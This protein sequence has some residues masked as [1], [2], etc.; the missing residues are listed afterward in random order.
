MSDEE[1][2][3]NDN[4]SKKKWLLL[5]LLLLL[6]I[7][8]IFAVVIFLKDDGT[9]QAL[10]ETVSNEIAEPQDSKNTLEDKPKNEDSKNDKGTTTNTVATVKTASKQVVIA[11]PG[12]GSSNAAANSSVQKE[13]V[14]VNIEDDSYFNEPVVLE[15]AGNQ[16]T[17][18]I[19]DSEGNTVT[20]NGKTTISEDGTYTLTI[21][22]T[23]G[24]E[25][26]VVFIVD[27]TAPVIEGVEEKLYNT[28]VT[29]SVK[30]TNL[31][32]VTLTKNGTN[33]EYS[34]GDSIEEDG[35]YTL[36]VIDK[37][38]NKASVS[39]EIDRTAPVCN[40]EY[41]ITTPTN[42]DV[43]VT[44][45]ASEPIF[46]YT[47]WD[48]AG[49][50]NTITK[51][52]T[53]NAEE[54]LLLKDEAGNETPVTVK[55]TN[56]D[57]DAPVLEVKANITSMTKKSVTIRIHANEQI[58]LPDN[59]WQYDDDTK[60]VIKKVY[61][62]NIETDV[63][64]KDLVGNEAT[65][66]IKITNIDKVAPTGSVTSSN[67]NG[68]WSTNK[69]VTA[70]LVVS[71]PVKPI[72][73]W[74][75]VDEYTYTK[76]YSSNQKVTVEFEDLVGN[77]G[78][79]S[80]EIKRIDKVPPVVTI[81]D[82]NK[83]QLEVH[84]PYVEKG[85]HAEDA[86][87][88]NVTDRVTKKY[89]FQAKGSS[90]WE[91]VNDIDTSKLG[92]YKITYTFTDKAGNEA[93][94]SRVV[95]IVDTT[96]PLL[97]LNGE[98]KMT[99][100]AGIDTYIELG[101]TAKDNYDETITN[102]QPKYIN[103]SVNNV[104]QGKVDA[105]D[106]T[107][108]GTYK[109]VYEYSDTSNN[110]GVDANRSDHAYVMRIVEVVDTTAP[111]LTLNGDAKIILEAGIDTY[112]ELGATV[113][114]NHDATI[115]NLQPKYINYSV[116]NVYQGKVNSVDNTK[117]GTYKIVYEHSDTSNNVGVDAN[118]SDH[119][120]VMRIV[121][122]VDTIAPTGKVT[123]SNNNGHWS[124][125]KDVTATLVVSE[126]IKPIDGWTKVDEYTY[127]K[128]Y[129][130]NQK[131]TV[132]FED[133]V[134][135]KGKV[136]FE[137]KRID[138][139]PPVVTI[140]D[141]NKYQLEVHSPYVEKGYHAEDAVDKNVT[142]RV[143]KKYQFQAKGSSNWEVV[144]DIDTSKLG[145]YKITY[146]FTD[147][148]G[149]EA[150]GSRV[151]EI[152]DTTAPLLTLNGDAKITLEYG[153]D[154]YV[155]LGATVTDNYDATITNLQPKYINYSVNNVF[156][157]TRYTM[158]NL[159]VGTYKVMY[160]YEDSSKN[161]GVD[162]NRSDHAYVMRTVTVV[163]TTAPTATVKYSTK[164]L[165]N[166]DVVVTLELSEE[167]MVS[168]AGTWNPASGY[169][170]SF[171][172]SYNRNTTQVVT[173]TDKYGNVGTVEV[174]IE[175][176]DKEAATVEFNVEGNSIEELEAVQRIIASEPIEVIGLDELV[177]VPGSNNTIY[178]YRYNLRNGNINGFTTKTVSVKDKAG[179]VTNTDIV[180]NIPNYV[181][182]TA[183]GT[184]ST[185]SSTSMRM[186]KSA[187]P[188]T[189]VASTSQ[190]TNDLNNVPTTP[191]IEEPKVEETPVVTDTP[192]VEE[193]KVEETPVVTETPVVEEPKVE[194]TPIVTETPVVEEPKVEETPVVTETPV[195]EEP[196]VE[197]TPVVTEVPVIEETPEVA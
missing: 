64:V 34:L 104:Y 63:V 83:Y 44:I 67:N 187:R 90:N 116:N 1:V 24:K 40:V 99:I 156:K 165:T 6:I 73:G 152:V 143:T 169:Q 60:M 18:T 35:E 128:V 161:I 9:A 155:E 189:S 108:L 150:S 123:S 163:D 74:T 27:T 98:A 68:H 89:Q 51:V 11:A 194:E 28:P 76:V 145:I 125:N 57:K 162:A 110:V 183:S 86:V 186:V 191:A 129:S 120:Y 168:N 182:T 38:G 134:G 180:I 3:N 93:S 77:K 36:E 41:S 81:T 179:N 69:D 15:I 23:D 42:Q 85:Y 111:L 56:I 112:T 141:S 130:S 132:E 117:L 61:R 95:E 66:H 78:K 62:Q 53:E 70:T 131:V 20:Y 192:V 144:N 46:G 171:K 65:A 107:K 137:I 158:D 7:F 33:V 133:L 43:T 178:E 47:G 82:S 148:A 80:F 157:E 138:K 167:A 17:A 114:D 100:E 102:L 195:V 149:N 92:I 146:I 16:F 124:T 122:V 14:K 31:D 109:I 153:R 96:A 177:V 32:K 190:S 2:R 196:K 121:E 45:T 103:Y 140:T 185:L 52:F 176:I 21:K 4:D 87:D 49:N 160:E 59:T 175:N 29:P 170:T 71:E 172:K 97:T 55:V 101:A 174:K 173:L 84:S 193:S 188:V 147:K 22:E 127:T 5:L 139:V 115:T 12:V 154:T 26:S 166:K 50:D 94:G 119:A 136:S 184:Q 54:N 88:K 118:R 13:L 79:V 10:D 19:T 25:T 106:N 159:E 197:E 126:P 91:V 113:T 72:D 39:F 164:D 151:V 30:E 75:K 37:A 48:K 142:D 8:V 181:D 58:Q 135:N 105:V